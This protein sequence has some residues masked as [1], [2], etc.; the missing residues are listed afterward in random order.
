MRAGREARV[1]VSTGF[2]AAAIGPTVG[3]KHA[4]RIEA[5]GSVA[6]C[7]IPVE[8]HPDSEA[9]SVLGRHGGALP[10]AAPALRSSH[11]AA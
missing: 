1:I 7:G 8:Y 10:Y 6:A 11:V 4:D 5:L 9:K 2:A 3:A